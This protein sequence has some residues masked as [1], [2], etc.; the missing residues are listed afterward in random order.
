MVFI[1]SCNVFFLIV[2][3]ALSSLILIAQPVCQA[4]TKI[5]TQKFYF[6]NHEVIQKD[7]NGSFIAYN[8]A[9][10]NAPSGIGS[11]VTL[12]SQITGTR[13]GWSYYSAAAI[14]ATRLES[15]LH[16]KGT[17][18][19]T[20]YLSSNFNLTGL[21][22]GGSYGFGVVDIDENNNEVT[23]F[24]SE[25][26]ISIGRNPFTKESAQYSL[27]VSVDYTFK[28]GHAIGFAVGFGATTKGFDATIYFDSPATNSAAT[29]PLEETITTTPSPAISTPVASEYPSSIIVPVVAAVCLVSL[30]AMFLRSRKIKH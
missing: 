15:D 4:Q 13:D 12:Q 27:S 10:K 25:G 1:K 24:I 17:V 20:A 19:I 11:Q 26:P 18:T 14:W 6:H 7:N 29:V 30:A 5:V 9:D 8:G 16:V 2:L 28:K 3:L 23:E 21:F 22:S